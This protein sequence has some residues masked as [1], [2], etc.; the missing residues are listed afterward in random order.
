VPAAGREG[1]EPRCLLCGSPQLHPV[2]RDCRDLLLGHPGS[3]SVLACAN[4]GLGRTD[5][6]PG[7]D[8]IASYYSGAYS[9][10]VGDQPPPS[11]SR[12]RRIALAVRDAPLLAR[13]GRLGLAPRP[14]GRLLDLGAGTGIGL[15]LRRAEGWD[16]WGVEPD[17]DAV[18]IARDRMGIEAERLSVG[19]AEDAEFPDESFDAIVL[20]HV[21]EHLH[22]PASVLARSRSWIRPGGE[23]L[24]AC[25]N[26]ASFER[27]LFGR[28]WLGLDVP[29]HLHHF[30]PDTLS[31]LV[32]RSGFYVTSLRPQPGYVTPVRSLFAAL[33]GD[34]LGG[35]ARQRGWRP[36]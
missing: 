20:H 31:A 34:L 25:P 9:A 21:I 22:D 32:E 14:G 30:T 12:A 24:V 27:R 7:P 8:A 4:C 26:F 36:T 19:R 5:P 13:F 3:W 11:P 1:P 28:H 15:A 23:L 10:Y 2:Y 29:R 35:E 18:A 6:Q 33:R 16:V 17:P